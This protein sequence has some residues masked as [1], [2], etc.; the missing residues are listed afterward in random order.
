MLYAVNLHGLT[1]IK[2]QK[3]FMSD[4]GRGWR[5]QHLK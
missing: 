2:V 5:G 3:I 1:V 4:T